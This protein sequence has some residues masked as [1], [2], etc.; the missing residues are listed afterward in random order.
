MRK[1]GLECKQRI[2]GPPI[3]TAEMHRLIATFFGPRSDRIEH[4]FGRVLAVKFFRGAAQVILHNP[5][6]FGKNSPAGDDSVF[7]TDGQ[8]QHIANRFT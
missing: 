4:H 1:T 6:D 2:F 7:V 8:M 3:T 5:T